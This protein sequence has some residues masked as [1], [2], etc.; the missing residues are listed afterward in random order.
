MC[1]LSLDF[2]HMIQISVGTIDSTQHDTAIVQGLRDLVF[3]FGSIEIGLNVLF[4]FT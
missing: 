1:A 3:P 4:G 2:F